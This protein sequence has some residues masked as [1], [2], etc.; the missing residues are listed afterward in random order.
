MEYT[1]QN[2]ACRHVPVINSETEFVNYN[3]PIANDETSNKMFID[4][5]E[6]ILD[7][8]KSIIDKIDTVTVSMSHFKVMVTRWATKDGKYNNYVL[9]AESYAQSKSQENTGFLS[10]FKS[11]KSKEAEKQ[12]FKDEYGT[13][14]CRC[15]KV[16]EGQILDAIRRPLGARTLD[17]IKR[18]T[19]AGMGRCQGGFCA[20]RVMELLS[21]ELGVPMEQLT[22]AGGASRLLVGI[23]KDSV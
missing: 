14:I 18:R 13:I 5:A 8:C 17:G 10:K 16:T 22:K 9:E 15:E 19:R 1:L 20:P 11:A 7:T 4:M 2:K 6:D 23:N 21:R 12:A 3:I